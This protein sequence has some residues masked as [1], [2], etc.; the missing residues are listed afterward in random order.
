MTVM[1]PM[2]RLRATEF[3]DVVVDPGSWRSWDE[4]IAE[5]PDAD[6]EYAADLARARTRN[7]R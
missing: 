7:G 6:T 1:T 3:L 4:P 2:A 5:P